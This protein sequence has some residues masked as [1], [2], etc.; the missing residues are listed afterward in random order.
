MV[1]FLQLILFDVVGVNDAQRHTSIHVAV[2]VG[3]IYKKN[4][5]IWHHLNRC[6]HDYNQ[7]IQ[8]SPWKVDFID[9]YLI[10]FFF[11]PLPFLSLSLF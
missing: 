2:A 8:E 10:D 7:T 1:L 9:F 4:K 5:T 3:K 6:F 11:H